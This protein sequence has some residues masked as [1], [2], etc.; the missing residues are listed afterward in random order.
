MRLRNKTWAQKLVKEHPEA[1]LNEPAPE[2]KINWEERFED[3]SKPLA[4]EIGS[5]KGQFITTLAKQHPEMNFIAVELQTTAAGMILRTK[6]NEGIDNLQ[7]MCAD[8]AN[9]AIYLPKDSVDTLY[10]NFSDPW[11]KTRH[12]KRR[13]TYKS[14]LDKYKEVLKPEGHLE[15]KTDNRGLFEYSLVSLNNYGMKFD[16]VSVD[17]HHDE[18]EIAERNVETEYEHKF[19]AKGNPIYC[20]HAHFE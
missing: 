12:E 10:L 1:I 11:P 9:I 5:G 17:L 15:F 13:L 18:D 16:H 8:A 20:L 19:V 3:F 7:I 2:V 14:F 4:I 6:L